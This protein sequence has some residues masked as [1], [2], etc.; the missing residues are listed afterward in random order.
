MGWCHLPIL[1][2]LVMYSWTQE[3]TTVWVCGLSEPTVRQTLTKICYYLDLISPTLMG[4]PGWCTQSLSIS[5][6]SDAVPNSP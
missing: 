2:I 6:D 1:L 3:V 5:F 4:V